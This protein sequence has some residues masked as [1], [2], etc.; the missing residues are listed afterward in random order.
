M[1]VY[2]YVKLSHIEVLVTARLAKYTN[3]INVYSFGY[4]NSGLSYF[5][6]CNLCSDNSC[7]TVSSLLQTPL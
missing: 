7:F 4:S 1:Y 3:N 6:K 2:M 5:K